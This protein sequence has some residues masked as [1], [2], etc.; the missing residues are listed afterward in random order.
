MKLRKNWSNWRQTVM[1]QRQKTPLC[2]QVSRDSVREGIILRK[3]QWVQ[4]VGTHQELD[5]VIP[6]KTLD[7]GKS[8]QTATINIKLTHRV[9]LSKIGAQEV[10]FKGLSQTWL[11]SRGLD[12]ASQLTLRSMVLQLRSRVEIGECLLLIWCRVL[13]LL[14]SWHLL[15]QM[16]LVKDL[17]DK[18]LLWAKM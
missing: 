16:C 15:S 3:I 9:K 4:R 11:V 17:L 6:L 8:L 14:L 10:K 7:Q 13:V 1:L 12:Q 2:V 5:M 18:F